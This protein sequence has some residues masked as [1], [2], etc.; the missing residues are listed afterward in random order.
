MRD[1]VPS[2]SGLVPRSHNNPPADEAEEASKPERAPERALDPRLIEIAWKAVQIIGA[3]LDEA[4]EVIAGKR[5]ARRPRLIR[6]LWHYAM[7]AHFAP[8]PKIAEDL[9]S[10]R[11]EIAER[12]DEIE[13]ALHARLGQ[14]FSKRAL[15][16]ALEADRALGACKARRDA[17]M[18]EGR[19]RNWMLGSISGVGR[20]QVEDDQAEIERWIA[21]APLIA[22]AVDQIRDMLE[23]LPG[24]HDLARSGE[25]VE[26]C[27]AEARKDRIAT[28][29]REIEAALARTRSKDAQAALK[30]RAKRL[31]EE[32]EAEGLGPLPPPKEIKRKP[33]EPPP[34]KWP[35]TERARFMLA[36]GDTIFQVVAELERAGTPMAVAQVSKLY[37]AMRDAGELNAAR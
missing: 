14:S 33:P 3:A 4:P 12:K 9:A 22:A 2:A 21:R 27:A 32:V 24:L 16:A 26:A 35:K 28:D 6:K 17:L 8:D 11:A 23:P 34:A 31:L 10:V 37:L 7:R 18:E 29:L 13:E 19:G 36:R 5:Q 15:E 25:L 20:D 30:A 1:L